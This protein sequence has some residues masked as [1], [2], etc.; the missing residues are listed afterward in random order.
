VRP[1]GFA[2][3]KVLIYITTEEGRKAYFDDEAAPAAKIP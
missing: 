3:G 1:N 2:V